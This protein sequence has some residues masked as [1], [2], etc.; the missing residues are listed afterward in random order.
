MD[1]SMSSGRCTVTAGSE[2]FRR[3]GFFDFIVVLTAELVRLCRNPFSAPTFLHGNLADSATMNFVGGHAAGFFLAV[4]QFVF[5]VGAGSEY[6][7][8]VFSRHLVLLSGAR[9]RA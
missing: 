6:D 7:P 2:V 1:R 4:A 5:R 3:D 9:T 8:V